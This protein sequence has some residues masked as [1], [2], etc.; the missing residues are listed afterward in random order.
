M[1]KHHIIHLPALN[2][3]H[4]NRT[5]RIPNLGT[6]N[7]VISFNR[8]NSF[9]PLKLRIFWHIS[10]YFHTIAMIRA[11]IRKHLFRASF[12]LAILLF[13]IGAAH[14]QTAHTEA[15]RLG[16]ALQDSVQKGDI[17]LFSKTFNRDAFLDRVLQPIKLSDVLQENLR[18][19][20][21]SRLSS[22]DVAEAVRKNGRNFT[23]VG[24]RRIGNEYQ[25]LFRFLGPKNELVYYG[26]PMGKSASGAITLVDVFC[27]A[28]P[29]LMSETIRR[30]CLSAIARA[31]KSA[32][33]DWTD[34]QK[35]YIESQQDWNEFASQCQAA[36]HAV[37]EKTY[38]KLPD[39]LRSDPYVL[40]QRARVAIR[41]DEPTFLAAIAPWQRERPNDPALQLIAS[42]YCVLNNRPAE[43]I[44]AYD[45][46][47]SQ[48]GGD[49]QLD[50]RIA[51]LHASLGHTN[52]TRT[53]LWQAINRDPPDAI[54]FAESLSWSLSERNFEQAARVLALQEKMFHADLKP[55]I[56]SD[57]RFK[58]FRQSA[59]GKKW[60]AAGPI[61]IDPDAPP[62]ASRPTSDTLKLQAIL[63]GTATPS[64]LINGKTL[65]VQDKI[66]TYQVV[67]IEPQSVTLR[68][69]SGDMRMLALGAGP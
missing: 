46:L 49:P 53:N 13:T 60:L 69:S 42:D 12:V 65:F 33:E 45:K 32:V 6:H 27:F 55:G 59:P 51:K 10:S 67:K 52:E 39:S 15:Y 56:R 24:V 47:N 5:T 68:S 48:L 38:V 21:Q 62:V 17:S 1:A 43:A 3:V 30:G 36:R 63:F 44:K 54:A 66:G 16:I 41:E 18:T 28:P 37:A 34:K 11:D 29:E 25:L 2:S 19:N 31:D 61:V 58:E 4:S 20:L 64:A 35:D 8:F 14:S 26:Y 23:F 57:D 50:L 40:Y 22:D 9:N 7:D